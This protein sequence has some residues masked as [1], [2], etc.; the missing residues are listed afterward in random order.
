MVITRN[1]AQYYFVKRFGLN[2]FDI[3]NQANFAVPHHSVIIADYSL[4][5]CFWLQK[6]R[7]SICQ[8]FCIGSSSFGNYLLAGSE[9]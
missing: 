7:S 9:A 1:S 4:L 5:H 8:G 2:I 6:F 3:L